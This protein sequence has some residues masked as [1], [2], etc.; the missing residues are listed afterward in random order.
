MLGWGKIS[1]SIYSKH[2]TE[3]RQYIP[4][5]QFKSSLSDN[6]LFLQVALLKILKFSTFCQMALQIIP[7]Q[8][9]HFC[10][11]LLEKCMILYLQPW[12]CKTLAFIGTHQLQSL[13]ILGHV[14]SW[15]YKSVYIYHVYFLGNL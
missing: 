1:K 11:F 10:H 5:K 13:P 3:S 15:L 2:L 4:I 14:S 6:L 9:L 7:L 12:D 8:N